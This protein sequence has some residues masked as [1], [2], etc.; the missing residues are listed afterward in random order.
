MSKRIVGTPFIMMA[1]LIPMTAGAQII[2][3]QGTGTVD[4]EPRVVHGQQRHWRG[5][6]VVQH[7]QLQPVLHRYVERD[8]EAERDCLWKLQLHNAQ[9]GR[10]QQ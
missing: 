5:Q 7:Q 4:I 9:P 10:R 1:L 6:P 2:S 8:G 3:V